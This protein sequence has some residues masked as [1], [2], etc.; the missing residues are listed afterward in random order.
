MDIFNNDHGFEGYIDDCVERMTELKPYISDKEIE[1][2][3]SQL[4][5][6]FRDLS[7][8]QTLALFS[9]NK[10]ALREVTD[11][12][13]DV[14]GWFSFTLRGVYRR[15]Y[16]LFPIDIARAVLNEQIIPLKRKK[17]DSRY[18][19]WSDTDEDFLSF[20]E[21]EKEILQM[22]EENARVFQKQTPLLA[23]YIVGD[24]KQKI[25]N[26][27]NNHYSNE[28]GIALAKLITTLRF[29]G[30]CIDFKPADFYRAF[31]THFDKTE[32]LNNHKKFKSFSE[33]VGKYLRPPARTG[34][35]SLAGI[36]NRFSEKDIE[37]LAISIGIK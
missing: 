12:I 8:L 23:E 14:I 17:V 11:D 25:L 6:K 24:H 26:Y 36:T 19:G 3:K 20:F 30:C 4:D 35:G 13:I 28:S 32:E 31:L 16:R 34:S 33:G 27:I 5:Y 10:E 18:E 29:Y 15:V 9:G 21:V 2:I 37:N 1:T 7:K 22:R